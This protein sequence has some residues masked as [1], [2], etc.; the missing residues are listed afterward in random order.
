MSPKTFFHAPSGVTQIIK[1]RFQ[2][3]GRGICS[4]STFLNDSAS[5]R[6]GYLWLVFNHCKLAHF[7]FLSDLY[8]D[9]LLLYPVR[10]D[11]FLTSR[12][13]QSS[14]LLTKWMIRL[15]L[16]GG[17]I[18]PNP[19]PQAPKWVCDICLKPITK[20]QTSILC[21]YTKH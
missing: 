18:H 16:L 21:Y 17:E 2:V 1:V 4:K 14:S 3:L 10:K 11:L 9:K 8:W 5:S 19:G 12:D 13:S 20:H 15:L 6:L 7:C